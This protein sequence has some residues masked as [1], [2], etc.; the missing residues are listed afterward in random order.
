MVKVALA[1]PVDGKCA[2]GRYALEKFKAR[3]G[4]G[5]GNNNLLQSTALV[6]A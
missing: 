6:F 4:G 1:G 2:E 5:A 3:A